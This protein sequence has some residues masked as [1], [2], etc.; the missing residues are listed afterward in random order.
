MHCDIIDKVFWI[1]TRPF[2]QCKLI[3]CRLYATFASICYQNWIIKCRGSHFVVMWKRY[4]RFL[5][6]IPRLVYNAMCNPLTILTRTG[7][8]YTGTHYYM[9]TININWFS[10]CFF[11]CSLY[12]WCRTCIYTL[13]VVCIF[14]LNRKISKKRIYTSEQVRYH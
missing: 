3:V 5:L 14:Q 7:T 13:T 2:M 8:L 9:Y 6:C 12:R 1:V 11:Y 4:T 10:P